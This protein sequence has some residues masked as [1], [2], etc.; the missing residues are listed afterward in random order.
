MFG[1]SKLDEAIGNVPSGSNVLLLGPPMT[2]KSILVRD[3]FYTGLKEGEG[4]I[5]ITTKDTASKLYQ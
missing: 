3:F 1:I 5:Y 2:V 4:V